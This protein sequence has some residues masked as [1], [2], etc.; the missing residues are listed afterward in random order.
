MWLYAS[1]CLVSLLISVWFWTLGS[2]LVIGFAGIEL[3]VLG[4]AFLAYARHATDGETV[5]V[6]GGKLI[7]E[8]E[9]AGRRERVEFGCAQARIEPCCQPEALIEVN[10]YGKRVNLGRYLRP[11]WRP[12]VAGEISRALRESNQLNRY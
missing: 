12:L 3:L 4:A 9:C 11:E 8:K 2:K 7:V 1:L 10:G 5:S 6:R